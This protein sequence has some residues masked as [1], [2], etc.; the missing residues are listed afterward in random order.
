MKSMLVAAL[1]VVFGLS[2]G[3]ANGQQMAF[4][5][6]AEASESAAGGAIVATQQRLPRQPQ[7][8]EDRPVRPFSRVA[9]GTRLG[10]LGYGAQIATPL[11]SHLNLRGS[12][13]FFNFGYGI[14][15]DGANYESEL[16]LKS[17][18][19]S[20]DY[21]P[22]HSSFHVSPGFM[23]FK[24]TAGATMYVP[25]GSS[26]SLGDTGYTSDPNDPVHGSGAMTFGRTIMPA[27]TLG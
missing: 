2:T 23:I 4:S 19:V 27:L 22:F 3:Q 7:S 10:T 8:L 25:G 20:V 14:G 17:G 5:S 15:I 1:T 11:T 24:S 13:N 26:F 21:F 12:A 6:S 16:H 18:M 9:I